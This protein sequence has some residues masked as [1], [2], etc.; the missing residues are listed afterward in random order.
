[1]RVAGQ[2]F[3]HLRPRQATID[4]E[5]RTNGDKKTKMIDLRQYRNCH[6]YSNSGLP[7]MRGLVKSRLDYTVAERIKTERIMVKLL[8]RSAHLFSRDELARMCDDLY[9]GPI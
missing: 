1:M 2:D 8:A 3:R 7:R 9:L 6:L 4:T 5:I